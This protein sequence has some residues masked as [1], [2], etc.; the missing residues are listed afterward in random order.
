MAMSRAVI[1]AMRRSGAVRMGSS[2]VWRAA[3]PAVLVPTMGNRSTIVFNTNFSRAFSSVAELNFTKT[4]EWVSSEG[5]M[6]ISDFAQ[7]QLGEV[8]YCDLPEEGAE[9]SAKDTIVTLESVK[10]VGEV[11]APAD[12]K[13]VAVNENLTEE[14]ALVN[15]SPLKDGWLIKIQFTGEKPS[16]LNSAEYEKHVESE[17]SES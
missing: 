13:V 6:G 12:C 10:A 1:G 7:G 4:H 5:A 16:L 15:S 17:A 2:G 9:F 14:P 3:P 8:V 11:Y